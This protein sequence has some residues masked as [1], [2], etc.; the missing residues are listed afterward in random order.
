MWN[1]N[2]ASEPFEMIKRG[3]KTFELRLYD[4]K[5]S[6]LRV[7]DI[8][9]FNNKANGEKIKT[10]ILSLHR[11]PNFAA[12]YDALPLLKCG[13]TEENVG[14]ASPDDMNKYYPQEKQRCCG[15]LAIE[16]SIIED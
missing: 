10:R 5:R 8:V 12:L 16:I 3:L 15:V 14:A 4:E 1:M 11:F 6:A 7:G 9:T 2:L 13:Y